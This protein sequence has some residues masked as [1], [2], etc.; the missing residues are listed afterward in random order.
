MPPRTDLVAS[1][2]NLPASQRPG[3]TGG[4]PNVLSTLALLVPTAAGAAATVA[5][6]SPFALIAGAAVGLFASMAPKIGRQWE[7]A[8]VLRMGRYVGLRGPGPFWVS[9]DQSPIR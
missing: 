3:A 6:H 4:G 9:L 5:M 2:N 8:V 1:L 7:R